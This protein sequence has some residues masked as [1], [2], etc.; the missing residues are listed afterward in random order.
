MYLEEGTPAFCLY[1]KEI[2]RFG[3]KEGEELSDEI[4]EKITELLSKRA[5][6]RALY[7]LDDMARTEQQ[8]RNKLKEGMYPDEAVEY[9]LSYCKEKHYIDDADYARRYIS[10]RADRLSRRMIE[11]K[12]CEKGIS[13]DIIADALEESPV[14]E[15]E[16]IR[17]LIEKK[18]GDIADSSFEE[19]QK[20]IRRFM[21]AGFS[22]D[23]VKDALAD[24]HLT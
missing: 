3:L 17:N 4:R 5:R 12:L 9:A 23:S 10:S 11:K 22:Y 2:T 15:V 14:S 18:Y 6:E 13:R 21:G 7:L 16:T 20:I 1:T 8:I 19:R 24:R